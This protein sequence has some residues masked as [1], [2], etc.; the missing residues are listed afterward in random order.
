[1]QALA[2]T[3]VT[4]DA[5]LISRYDGR[6]P[7][8]TSYPA[9]PEF[10]TEFKAADYCEFAAHSNQT[11]R[12]LSIYVHIPFCNSLCYYCG[13]N[14]VVTRNQNRVSSYLKN[15]H[16]EI[17]MQAD[18]F[19]PTRPVQ[20]LHLGGGTPTYLSDQQL[21]KLLQKLA[22]AFSF[23]P[24]GEREFSIEVDPRTV[25]ASSIELHAELGFNRLS[26]G[27]QDF[28][29]AVQRAV[30]RVQS[31]AQ[32]AGLLAAARSN[33]F[34]SVSFDLIYGLP[35]QTEE[36]FAKTL[37]SVIEMRP[38]R[39][40]VYNYAHLPARFKG[41]RMIDADQIPAPA[42]KLRLLQLTIQKLLAA[43]Y[44]YV[45]MDHF[46]LPEDDLVRAR[47]SRTLQ[48]NFQGYSTHRHCDLVGLG[49]SSISKIGNSFAQNA[50]TTM[51]YQALIENGRL[52]IRRG[53]AIDDDDL[54]RA[55][56]IQTLMCYDE[57][58]FAEFNSQYSFSFRD[59]FATELESLAPHVADGL[60]EMDNH[61]MRVTPCGRLLMRN[62]AMQFDRHLDHDSEIERFS[63]AI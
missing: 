21:R 20:Q 57:V 62:I 10:N 63:K 50:T 49:V 52:P 53:I 48:R 25:D 17:E 23:A 27:V 33:N 4:F 54:I 13:C 5:D 1:M 45:G 59:Y 9:A 31:E 6:G 35:L 28:D 40:A 19:A 42:V 18:L 14:K 12:A 60:V 16:R 46:A 56:V 47:R 29:P 7:R 37:Q 34:R 55:D 58:V 61:R 38:D 39:I 36:S 15:L 44:C 11:N 26:L 41:Q 3:N 22:T 43:G 32:I 2:Q 24:L 51:E 30:N 8:Y